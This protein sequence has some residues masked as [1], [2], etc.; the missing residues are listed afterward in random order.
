[1]ALHINKKKMSLTRSVMLVYLI[2]LACVRAIK[3]IIVFMIATIV[4]V[5]NNLEAYSSGILKLNLKKYAE[6]IE[7]ITINKSMFSI[8]HDGTNLFDIKIRILPMCSIFVR[9]LLCFINLNKTT[10]YS[11]PIAN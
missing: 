10:I 2:I 3:S 7:N 5:K 8:I 6:T 11:K 1:M 9:F 4:T